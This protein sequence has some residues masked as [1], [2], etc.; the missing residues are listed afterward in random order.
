MSNCHKCYWADRDGDTHLQAVHMEPDFLNP[1]IGPGDSPPD[2]RIVQ[3]CGVGSSF[4]KNFGAQD[5]N[6]NKFVDEADQQ[7]LEQGE[8]AD[9]RATWAHP[10]SRTQ[11]PKTQNTMLIIERM[12]GGSNAA[13]NILTDLM[14]YHFDY[15]VPTITH[16]D[17][18][19]MR[20]DQIAIAFSYAGD[21]RNLIELARARDKGMIGAVN[22]GYKKSKEEKAITRGAHLYGHKPGKTI[23]RK[24]K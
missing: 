14:A 12:A 8:I 18:M 23:L 1:Y 6:C 16:L 9:K 10:T 22:S 11:L 13:F 24:P 20:G 7:E 15:M 5:H 17:D 19:N 21:L 4:W 2:I 3:S